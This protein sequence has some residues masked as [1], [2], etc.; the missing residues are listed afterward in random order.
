M[1]KI[2]IY[3]VSALLAVS[4][5][6]SCTNFE[7][8]PGDGMKAKIATLDNGLKIYMTVDKTEPRLQTMIAVRCGGKNDPSD[9]TGL[10]HYFEHMMF[11]GTEKLGTSDFEAEK[12]LLDEIESLFEVYRTQTDPAERKATYARIDSL[13]YAASLIS[14]PNEYDKAMAVIGARGTNAFTSNDVTCYVEDIPSNR[15]DEWAMVQ[16]DRFRNCTLRGFHTELETIYEEYNMS[17]TKDFRN[18]MEVVDSAIFK[19]HP[20]GKQTVLG[21]SDHLKNPSISA[22]KTQ[23]ARYYVPNN[24]AIC[25]SGDFN[26]REFVKTVEKYFGDWEPNKD[27]PEFTFAP[28]NPIT[29][30]VEKTLTGNDAEFVMMSWR[31]PGEKDFKES[32]IGSVAADILF[33]GIAGIIDIDINQ[34]QKALYAGAFHY[35]RADYGEIIL[36]GMPKQG[37]SLE[38]VRDLILEAVAKLRDGNFDD[39]LL[40]AVKTNQKR[41]IMKSLESNRSRAMI[42]VDSFVNGVAWKDQ[43]G[44]VRRLEKITKDDVVAWAGKHLGAQSYALVYKT[45]GP[46]PKND[47]IVAPKITPIATNRDSRSAFL[48]QLQNTEVKPIEPVFYDYAKDLTTGKLRE[49]IDLVYKRNETNDLT[50][51]SLRFD[52]GLL[53]DPDLNAAFGYI[54]YLGTPSMSASERSMEMYVLGC[55][56][57]LHVDATDFVYTL[58]G[59]DENIGRALAIV[60]DLILEAIP[61]EDVLAS[62]KADLFK[63]RKDAKMNQGACFSALRDYQQYGPDYIKASTLSDSQIESAT[64]EQLLQKAASILKCAHTITYYGPSSEKQVKEMLSENHKAAA[65]LQPL[66]KIRPASMRTQ[67]PSVL[68]APYDSRQFQ[69]AQYADRGDVYDITQE[70]G[71][72]IYNEYFGSGM[73]GIVF[74]EMREARALAY[75]A[76]AYLRKPWWKDGDCTY[77]AIIYSQNDKLKTAV[78]A[79]DEIIERMPRS[80]KAFSVAKD[81][82]EGQLRTNR[83]TGDALI[84]KY[85][86][87]R[88]LGLS[89]PSDKA[90]FE[91]LQGF[92]LD[93]LEAFQSRN[94]K[95]L[96]FNFAILGQVD[97]LDKNYLSTLG[98][99]KILTLEEIFGY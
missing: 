13:S 76:G 84:R 82:L 37:Q 34:Q 33:N 92:T 7:T 64:S 24:I 97:G 44:A 48:E 56:Y 39:R 40:E 99:V 71:Y 15:I 23:K 14:I 27:L 77:I 72:R 70:A 79:F 22:I 96:P 50:T 32:E 46:N 6:D 16:A 5:T 91:A 28:E 93:D 88:E 62:L 55:E 73:N 89:E 20:Y 94:V 51:L 66:E 58:S 95:G 10:A 3:A 75:S 47:K 25:V 87:D 63:S 36:E 35:G 19:N 85:L 52:K 90:V 43:A 1:K 53:T 98:P 86:T 38:Q 18:A 81:G 9:N 65:E 8:V 78:E 80:E 45:V 11:K 2:L 61:D 57:S 74:Q 83:Y 17:L 26:P 67:T 12:P 41:E 49:G 42:F 59:L 60:E 54:D 69:Y 31:V 30:P 21:A 29:A 4:L 68:I